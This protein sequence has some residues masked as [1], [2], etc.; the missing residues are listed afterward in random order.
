MNMNSN[1]LMS[2]MTFLIYKI[3]NEHA[4]IS[5]TLQRSTQLVTADVISK[6]GLDGPVSNDLSGESRVEALV[7]KI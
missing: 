1:V 2:T 7:G 6:V 4:R 3:S 5:R